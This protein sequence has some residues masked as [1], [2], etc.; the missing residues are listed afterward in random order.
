[1]TQLNVRSLGGK[2]SEALRQLEADTSFIALV[3]GRPGS[4]SLCFVRDREADRTTL[5][6]R[7]E[8]QRTR[9]TPLQFAAFVP[10]VFDEVDVCWFTVDPDQAPPRALHAM[11]GTTD[12]GTRQDL[13]GPGDER[14]VSK[15]DHPQF[16][17]R[18]GTSDRL[19]LVS[20]PAAAA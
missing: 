17:A 6:I 16:E 18:R 11:R 1:M 3:D 9:V 7:T 19:G 2:D 13:D 14:I 10:A 8:F 20:S 5:A 15:F 12:V 4:S